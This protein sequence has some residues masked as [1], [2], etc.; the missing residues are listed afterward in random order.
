MRVKDNLSDMEMKK[1]KRKDQLCERS[2][3]GE[4]CDG[5]MR[6][7]IVQW[8][9]DHVRTLFRGLYSLNHL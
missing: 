1:A 6:V 7:L 2:M 5:A 9:E 8:V 3:K 4:W